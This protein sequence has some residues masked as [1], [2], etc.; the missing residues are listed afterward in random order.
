MDKSYP[1]LRRWK[2]TQFSFEYIFIFCSVTWQVN[3]IDTSP[4]IRRPWES[5]ISV[6]Y[7]IGWKFPAL[8]KFVSCRGQSDRKLSQIMSLIIWKGCWQILCIGPSLSNGKYQMSCTVR[9]NNHLSAKMVIA[10]CKPHI[11]YHIKDYTQRTAGLFCY[12]EH[13]TFPIDGNHWKD[14]EQ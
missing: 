8:D 2:K 4:E 12:N 11:L 7:W 1:C 6:R 3:G 10:K 14:H 13:G 5:V 9:A